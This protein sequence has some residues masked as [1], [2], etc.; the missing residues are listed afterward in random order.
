MI[1]SDNLQT[2]ELQPVLAE[3]LKHESSQACGGNRMPCG[4]STLPIALTMTHCL[5][6]EAHVHSNPQRRWLMV[7][8]VGSEISVHS[9][10]MFG[11]GT[12]CMR[13]SIQGVNRTTHPFAGQWK[14]IPMTALAGEIERLN[15]KGQL[16]S[17]IHGRGLLDSH[18]CTVTHCD[19]VHTLGVIHRAKGRI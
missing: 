9:T 15:T 7:G 19:C 4:W 13:V 18:L 1:P 6:C 5:V 2:G 14:P 3:R 17:P 12:W 11:V 8:F 10:K 16:D